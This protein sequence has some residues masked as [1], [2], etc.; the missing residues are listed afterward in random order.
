VIQVRPWNGADVFLSKE[1]RRLLKLAYLTTEY[2]KVSHTFIRR[3]ILELERRGHTLIRLAIREAGDAIADGA[4]R[5]ET[6]RTIHFMSLSKWEIIS[7]FTR[8]VLTRPCRWLR[9]LRMTLAMSNAS[10]RGLLRHFAY[11][12]EASVL[13]RIVL[14][15]SVQHIHVHFGTNAA[16]V[17]RLIR[18]LGGPPYSMTVHGPVEF[19]APLGFSLAEKAEDAAFVVA[20]SYFCYAQLCRWVL[21][22]RWNKIHIVRCSVNDDFFALPAP[23]DTSSRLFLS[24]GRLSA[25]KG[26]LLLLEAMKQIVAAEPAAQLV[27]AGDGELR[28]LIEQRIFDLDLQRHV[29]VTGWVDEATVRA[30]LRDARVLVQPSFAEGL[31]VVIMEALAM[32]RP[33]IST[34]VAGIPELVRPDQNGWLVPAGNVDELVGAMNKALRASAAQLT[35][36][37][38]AGSEL[39]RTQ[40]HITTEVLALEA[41][42]SAAIPEES[43]T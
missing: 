12:A 27:L 3:E 2:P 38:R 4:D 19:D 32:C 40:H 5:L 37:G 25:Q 36:M 8:V 9:A 7:Q 14:N 39:V 29:K 23:V 35:A 10:E 11:L 41:L 28:E 13:L 24:I 17:A 6:D 18:C 30:Y 31:P 15:H 26:Q 34:P 1:P 33:V 16:A 42:L 20:I 22:T 21:P 43:G